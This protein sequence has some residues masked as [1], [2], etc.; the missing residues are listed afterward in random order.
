[1]TTRPRLVLAGAAAA[2][3]LVLPAAVGARTQDNP[4]LVATVGSAGAPDSYS[5]KLTDA[6]GNPVSQLDP[7]TYDIAVRDYAALHNFHLFGPGVSQTTDI[8]GTADTTWTVTFANGVYSY[9]CDAHNTVMHGSFRVGAAP[10][11]KPKPKPVALAAK[12]GPGKTI[13][14][15]RSSG[16]K[17]VTLKRGKARVTV[18]DLSAKDNFHLI[19]PGA[20]AKTGVAFKGAKTWSLTLRKGL[21]RFRSDAHPKLKGSFRVS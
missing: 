6:A 15:R 17:V 10:P 2:A 21:Y 11:P 16:A 14:L 7:G 3:L 12:V 8:E 4:K 13:S 9:Q 5:I 20:N 18:R 1:M 19:G